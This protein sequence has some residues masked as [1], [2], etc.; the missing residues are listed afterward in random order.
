MA[1]ELTRTQILAYRR[2]A[3]WLDERLPA[4]PDSLRRVAQAGV[5]DCGSGT[6]TSTRPRVSGSTSRS[7]WRPR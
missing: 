3:Q 6:P 2:R 4:G 5:Q 7:M 1:L